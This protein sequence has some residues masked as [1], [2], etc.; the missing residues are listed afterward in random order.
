MWVFQGRC[1]WEWFGGL[2]SAL[3]FLLGDQPDLVTFDSSC[4]NAS[5]T[6]SVPTSDSRPHSLGGCSLF[7]FWPLFM[8]P[9][10][11]LKVTYPHIHL[12]HGNLP[13]HCC[14]NKIWIFLSPFSLSLSPS[15][16]SI[17]NELW[18]A[19]LSMSLRSSFGFT[20]FYLAWDEVGR[21]VCVGVSTLYNGKADRLITPS[22]SAHLLEYSVSWELDWR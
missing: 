7:T 14:R 8:T 6:R 4:S 12:N 2:S 5:G 19:S 15:N 13:L 3:C 9:N 21:G 18:P 1:W 10:S 22:F 20:T 11:S 16:S 17:H